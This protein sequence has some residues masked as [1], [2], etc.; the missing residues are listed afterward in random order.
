MTR[1]T[2]LKAMGMLVVALSPAKVVSAATEEDSEYRSLNSESK[3][4]L[5]SES[6]AMSLDY[7]FIESG[8]RNLVIE[9]ANGKIIAI[10]FSEVF[11]ALEKGDKP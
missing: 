4:L 3:I 6:I 11:D 2:A 5:S 10:P 9:R 8:K 7:H 1:R